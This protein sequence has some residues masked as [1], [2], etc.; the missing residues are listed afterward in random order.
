MEIHPSQYIRHI[1]FE[2]LRVKRILVVS[3]TILLFFAQMVSASSMQGASVSISFYNKTMYYPGTELDN[4]I[5][6]KLTIANNGAEQIRFSLA[7]D[8]MFSLNFVGYTLKS[9]EMEHTDTFIRKRSTNNT[10]F[11]REI[12]LEP[13][14]EFS[15]IEN[16]KDYLAVPDPAVYIIEA[17]FYPNLFKNTSSTDMMSQKAISSNRLTL[18]V[19]P[20]P[21][22]AASK[23]LPLSTTTSQILRP[24]GIPPNEVVEQTIIARQRGLWDQYFLYMDVEQL[25]LRDSAR[26]RKYRSESA[27]G[28]ARMI[29]NYKLDLRQSRMD[30]D[31]VA[32]PV[33]FEIERTTY[34][35]N[36]GSV[37]VMQ[38]FQY[39]TY[40]EKK[41][42]T[43]YVRQR[44]GIWT[45][46]DYVVENMGTE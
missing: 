40:K 17:R 39:D 12:V 30:S 3:I 14:E 5:Y 8:R 19:T 21:S 32:I 9:T 13:G 1:D 42:Y 44:D 29:E 15:F 43:Y 26:S 16:V 45:I 36:E 18:E 41:R 10:V 28:R 20:P 7:D 24:E 23:S 2:E 27:E 35:E 11:F 6:V 25:L 34:T 46:Y 4:P 33:A 31:I 37:S 38:W 22:V